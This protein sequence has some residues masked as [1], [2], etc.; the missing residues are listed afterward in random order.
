MERQ[1]RKWE[2]CE[3]RLLQQIAELQKCVEVADRLRRR[4]ELSYSSMEEVESVSGGDVRLVLGVTSFDARLGVTSS[5]MLRLVL[6][7]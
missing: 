5:T 6:W 7:L 4:R 2:D 3:E 1:R